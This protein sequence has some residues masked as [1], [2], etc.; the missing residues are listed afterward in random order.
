M[1]KKDYFFFL[2]FFLKQNI[3]LITTIE[4]IDISTER[5][6]SFD[7]SIRKYIIFDDNIIKFY[8]KHFYLF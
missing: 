4:I 6:F 5:N 1:E 3:E 8:V 2:C 7:E